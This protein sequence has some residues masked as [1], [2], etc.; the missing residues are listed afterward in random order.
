MLKSLNRMNDMVEGCRIEGDV[1][2][3]GEDIY[4]DMDVN[5]LRKRVGW[6]FKNQTLSKSIYDNMAYG[7][8][9]HGIKNKAE[10]DE[11]VERSL[12]QCG[13]LG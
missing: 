3:D 10:L 12:R 7:P 8:R 9:T 4:G 5:H 13:D 2:L 11:I 1:L 6:F